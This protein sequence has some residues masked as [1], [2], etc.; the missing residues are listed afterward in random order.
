MV[1]RLIPH[2]RFIKPSPKEVGRYLNKWNGLENYNLQ[3]DALNRLFF[4]YAPKNDNT[5]DILLKAAALNDFYSTNILDIYS[6]AK[7]IRQLKIDDYLAEGKPE[8]VDKLRKVVIDDKERNLYSFA[9][10]YC[11]HHKPDVY[12][13]YDRYVDKVL[14][15]LRNTYQFSNF[16]NDELRDYKRFV[17]I[18]DDFKAFFGLNEYNYKKIDRYLW[19]VG[20]EQF[21][22]INDKNKGDI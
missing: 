15:Y 16:R 10:K 14:R 6:V 4:E 20:K 8:L 21:S 1:N 12:P 22:D 17:E 5:E 19:L 13:I 7:H 11:S 18:I 3:E 2:K 9:T